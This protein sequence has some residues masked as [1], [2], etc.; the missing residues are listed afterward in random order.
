MTAVAD[1][2]EES[3]SRWIE[4]G[5]MRLTRVRDGRVAVSEQRVPLCLLDPEL[6]H[7]DRLG[8]RSEKAL[9][10]LEVPAATV[11]IALRAHDP[12]GKQMSPRQ[13]ET[14]LGRLEERNRP[15]HVVE[16]CDVL[17]FEL[18]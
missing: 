15:P 11:R 13:V 9:G 5:G 3:T 1:I 7:V 18:R 4:A 10:Q 2:T 17:A 14:V 16:G 6:R 8:A 12:S